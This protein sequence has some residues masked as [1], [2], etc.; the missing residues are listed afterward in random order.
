MVLPIY[1]PKHT[2]HILHVNSSIIVAVIFFLKSFVK[3]VL[4]GKKDKM[5]RGQIRGVDRE[6]RKKI[7]SQ[8]YG[9]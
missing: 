3:G 1:T 4:G 6:R 7:V 9:M 2:I 5:F 8:I